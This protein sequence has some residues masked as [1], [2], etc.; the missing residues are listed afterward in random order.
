MAVIIDIATHERFEQIPVPVV[1]CECGNEFFITKVRIDKA[2]NVIDMGE[3][4]VC[5]VCEVSMSIE[6]A[7]E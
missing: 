4:L 3:L 2:L 7:T 5:G 1:A 6:R